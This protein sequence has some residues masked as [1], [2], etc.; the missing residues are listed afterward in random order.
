M[1]LVRETALH[2]ALEKARAQK[3]AAMTRFNYAT[4]PAEHAAACHEMM[5]AELLERAILQR[6][7]GDVA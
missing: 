7:R 5:A 6:L 3:E 2:K 4:T 1:K